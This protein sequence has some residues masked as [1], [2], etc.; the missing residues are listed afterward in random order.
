MKQQ[1]NAR[2]CLMEA[3]QLSNLANR[4]LGVY[5]ITAP[6]PNTDFGLRHE[7]FL[8]ALTDSAG[9]NAILIAHIL[10]DDG[11]Q[12]KR[13]RNLKTVVSICHKEGWI[14]DAERQNLEQK[15]QTVKDSNA[16]RLLRTFRNR[17]AA[18]HDV[19]KEFKGKEI[20]TGNQVK[21]VLTAAREVLAV[22]SNTLNWQVNDVAAQLENIKREWLRFLEDIP[23]NLKELKQYYE[24]VAQ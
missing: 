21:E 14:T 15:I 10:F 4:A 2:D 17:R 19:E 5:R 24:S 18:H 20:V 7:L 1:K 13:G 16:Y 8:N 23:A 9:R 22:C 12:G 3:V 6:V 11:K